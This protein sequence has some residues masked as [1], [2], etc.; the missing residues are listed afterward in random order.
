VKLYLPRL[1]GARL[2]ED[3]GEPTGLPLA[4]GQET[5]LMV[6]DD[7]AVS[8]TTQEMLRALGY[9]VLVAAD[10]ATALA[11]LTQ[12]PAIDLLFTD[13][14]LPGGM[15]GRQLADAALGRIRTLKVLYTTGYARNAIIHHGRL[16]AGVELILKPFTERELALKVR[17]VLDGK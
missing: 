16:D 9:T 7:Q 11:K 2:A 14:G 10:A 6:E 8:I 1:L 3:P 15:N 13:V 12:M 4:R 5:I 17:R